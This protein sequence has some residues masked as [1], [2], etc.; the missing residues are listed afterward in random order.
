MGKFMTVQEAAAELK[1]SRW[2]IY[3]LIW[4][5][6][7]PSVTVGRCRRIVWQSFDDYVSGLIEQAA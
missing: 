6:E 2:M 7:V 4:A 5:N 3:Q 1:V